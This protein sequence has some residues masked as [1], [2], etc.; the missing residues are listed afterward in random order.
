MSFTE[1]NLIQKSSPDDDTKEA[2]KPRRSKR[3]KKYLLTDLTDRIDQVSR[4]LTETDWASLES[5][6]QEVPKSRD[7]DRDDDDDTD[8]SEKKAQRKE[9]T[10]I[11]LILILSHT[12]KFSQLLLGIQDVSK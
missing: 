5:D 2:L 1:F 8:A 11:L 6:C 3:S 10:G 12:I 9:K 4:T 7:S